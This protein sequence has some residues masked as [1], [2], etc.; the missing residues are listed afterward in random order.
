MNLIA[1]LLMNSLYGKFGMKLETTVVDIF[2][3][4]TPEGSK[5]FENALEV[6]G[7]TIYDYINLDG[8][9]VIVRDSRVDIKYSEDQDMYHGLEVNIAIASAITAAAR[10]QMS[11]FKNNPLFNLYYTDTDSIVI[12][13][14]LPESMVG[15]KLGQLKL[16]H[17]VNRAV[18]LAPKVYGL[19]TEEGEEIIKVKGISHSVASELHINE[20]EYLL[21]KDSSKVFTQE[22][23]LKKV[24]EGEITVSDIAYTLK[25]T[26]N[27]RHSLYEDGIF[28][29]TAP[30]Y[31]DDITSK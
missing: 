31:Y 13:K 18:F 10:V 3:C 28:N 12:D 24:V 30:F 17:V 8:C 23:W 2:D 6:Y 5:L 19:I 25:V 26:S 11:V 7:E 20:L 4:S 14:Q 22:K 9:F 21:I 15:D 16:E 27:K 29:N 1:K